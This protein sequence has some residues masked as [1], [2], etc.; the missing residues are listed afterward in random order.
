MEP[1]DD[2]TVI[3]ARRMVAMQYRGN[4]M[5]DR[6]T[7]ELPREFTC[8]NCQRQSVNYPSDERQA[9]TCR[10]CGTRLGTL[11]EFRRFVEYRAV[12]SNAL[13]SGC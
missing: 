10:S 8:P 13:A 2:L 6:L 1:L 7:H 3:A 5:Q 12:R 9:V 11:A 4:T